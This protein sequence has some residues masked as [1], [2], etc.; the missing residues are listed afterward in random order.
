MYGDIGID[1]AGK[2]VDEIVEAIE[3]GMAELD[4]QAEVEQEADV[5]RQ[6]EG[7]QPAEAKRSADGPPDQE[8]PVKMARLEDADAVIAPYM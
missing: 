5:G 4:Q 6:T 1:V 7:K 2:G 3:N 8:P